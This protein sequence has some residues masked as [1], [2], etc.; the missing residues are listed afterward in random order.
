MKI[1]IL[2]GLP[3][4]GKSHWAKSQVEQHPDRYKR[5]NR[6]E[7]RSMIDNGKWGKAREKLIRQAELAIAELYLSHGYIVIVDD[8]N[9]SETAK[10]MW[11]EFA[12][13]IKAQIVI[14]DFTDVPLDV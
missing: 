5:I 14:Q 13:K 3:G 10:T 7:L 6:D 9:L 1:V 4:S 8:C 12:Q 2:R 11:E